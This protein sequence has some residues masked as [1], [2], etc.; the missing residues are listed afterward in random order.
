[1]LTDRLVVWQVVGG[2]EPE[3]DTCHNFRKAGGRGRGVPTVNE[4]GNGTRTSGPEEDL[5]WVQR[6]CVEIVEKQ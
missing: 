5:D 6:F 2:H 4:T 3:L 1:M